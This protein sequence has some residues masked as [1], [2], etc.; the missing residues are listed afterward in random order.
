VAAVVAQ[1]GN[2]VELLLRK[3]ADACQCECDRYGQP[4]AS[5]R[6]L[7][8][9][10]DDAAMFRIMLEANS[11]IQCALHRAVKCKAYNCVQEWIRAGK[12]LDYPERED[13]RCWDFSPLVHALQCADHKMVAL[14][15]EAGAS[16]GHLSLNAVTPMHVACKFANQDWKKMEPIIKTLIKYGADV[17]AEDNDGYTPLGLF[18]IEAL[19]TSNDVCFFDRINSLLEKGFSPNSPGGSGVLELCFFS[20][21]K[22]LKSHLPAKR[23][24][25]RLLSFL[26][27]FLKFV[28]VV[29]KKGAELTNWDCKKSKICIDSFLEITKQ[30]PQ[31]YSAELAQF[32]NEYFITLLCSFGS[33]LPAIPEIVQLSRHTSWLTRR[34]AL[35]YLEHLPHSMFVSV[36]RA[37][38]GELNAEPRSLQILCRSEFLKTFSGPHGLMDGVEK[39]FINAVYESM[40]PR[41]HKLPLPA[42]LQNFLKFG[43]CMLK[44][45]T[46]NDSQPK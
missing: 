12:P 31:E 18:C 40:G 14:L 35:M 5:A 26:K 30:P 36:L 42:T 44:A 33:A 16:V 2:L 8:L 46:D 1:K 29:V 28:D 21:P 34:C 19:E 24:P 17:N 38:E 15:L 10:S 39:L 45:K 20:F 27:C 32:M 22:H 9:T 6:D 4:R 3:G 43:S 11:E 7:V 13:G 23:T 41:N 25:E 37:T